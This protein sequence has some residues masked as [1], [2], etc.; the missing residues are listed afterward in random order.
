MFF[1]RPGGLPYPRGLKAASESGPNNTGPQ[2]GLGPKYLVIPGKRPGLYWYEGDEAVPQPVVVVDEDQW[3][4]GPVGAFAPYVAPVIADGDDWIASVRVDEDYWLIGQ[5]QPHIFS[6]AVIADEDVWIASI[7]FDEDLPAI[8]QVSLQWIYQKPVVSDDDSLSFVVQPFGLD[9]DYWSVNSYRPDVTPLQAYIADGDDWIASVPVD[10]DLPWIPKASPQWPLSQ[11]FMSDDDVWPTPA[12]P[13]SVD[14]DYWYIN[15][16]T[17]SPYSMP[18]AVWQQWNLDDEAWPSG[19][20]PD[21]PSPIGD[22][23][24]SPHRGFNLAAWKKKQKPLRDL[25]DD[26]EALYK[27][28]TSPLLVEKAERIVKPFVHPK[29][30]AETIKASTV[31]WDRV[32]QNIRAIEKLHALYE[33]EI[34]DDDDDIEEMIGLL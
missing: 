16:F 21:V 11:P 32:V 13:I 1:R 19:I 8:P 34:S 31:E 3:L 2:G 25:E 6:K 22:G 9:E 28:I 27:E 18:A 23:G 30:R 5:Y 29:L 4:N 20:V 15:P 14:E 10:E 26:I 7:G 17:T 33:Q 12:V 24:R